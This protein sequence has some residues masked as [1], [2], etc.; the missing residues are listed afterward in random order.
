MQFLERVR[1]VEVA[2]L[3]LLEWVGVI[4][5]VTWGVWALAAWF[6]RRDRERRALT[7]SEA[8]KHHPVTAHAAQDIQVPHGQGKILLVDDELSARKVHAKLLTGL[9]YEVAC[10]A[11]GKEALEYM[12]NNKAD[13]LVLDL[14]MPNMDGV[15]TFRKVKERH[16]EQRAIMLSGWAQP[17]KVEAMRELGVE[18]YLIKP[19]PLLTLARAVRETLVAPA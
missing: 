17:N 6:S 16:P 1:S 14:V 15:E 5:L 9:G 2:G 11:G 12:A 19:V 7:I 13:L 3:G 4:A 8:R 18:H 10:A